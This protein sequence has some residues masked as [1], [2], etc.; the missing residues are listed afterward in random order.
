MHGLKLEAI[1]AQG[2]H[3]LCKTR[4]LLACEGVFFFLIGGGQMG[5]RADNTKV[6]EPLAAT[7]EV[8]RCVGLEPDATHPRI[9]LEVNV[10]DL[11]SLRCLCFERE[12]GALGVNQP[13]EPVLDDLVR[14]AGERV[15][16]Q[17]R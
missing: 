1:L 3:A 10:D 8:E 7:R 9:D 11:A 12:R 16:D 5:H 14:F 15:V 2:A 6:R 17:D 13:G 4:E